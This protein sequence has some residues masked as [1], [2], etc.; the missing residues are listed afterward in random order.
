MRA[1]P[2]YIALVAAVVAGF[3]YLTRPTDHAAEIARL[4][5]GLDSLEQVRARV[6]SV[7]VRDT[8]QLWRQVRSTDTLTA[9]VET[10]KHDTVRVIEYVTRADSTIRS[11]A[12]AVLT[13]EQ[14]VAVRD[15]T[16]AALRALNASTE[17]QL[18]AERGKRVRDALTGAGVGLLAGMLWRR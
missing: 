1:V 2:W 6:D 12:A 18:R 8:L 10:W 5:A 16:N 15:S 11:C 9:T 3:A 13:C 7:F 14:R 17:R 4:R